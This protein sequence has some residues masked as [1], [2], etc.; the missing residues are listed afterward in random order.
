[1]FCKCATASNVIYIALKIKSSN[2]D[3]QYKI[4]SKLDMHETKASIVDF[5]I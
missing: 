4:N 2:Y 5:N 3:F 1:M